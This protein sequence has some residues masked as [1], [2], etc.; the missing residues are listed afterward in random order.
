MLGF[1]RDSL[2]EISAA[3]GSEGVDD[4][5]DRVGIVGEVAASDDVF[6]C[7][8]QR[9]LIVA[10]LVYSANVGLFVTLQESGHCICVEVVLSSAMG[11]TK[12]VALEIDAEALEAAMS[13]TT[14]L[15]NH[16]DEGVVIDDYIEGI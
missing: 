2:Q 8:G 4:V 14:N 7:E 5:D 11:H 15:G 1:E 10:E 6:V 13:V 3:S 16:V 9:A 12:V